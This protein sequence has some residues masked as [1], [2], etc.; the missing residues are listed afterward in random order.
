[1][2]SYISQAQNLVASA[3]GKELPPEERKEKAI[4][5]AALLLQ[6]AQQVQTPREAQQQAFIASLMEDRNSKL[7]FTEITDQCFRSNHASRIADQ[8]RFLIHKRGIPKGLPLLI[9]V[10]LR[11]FSMFSRAVPTFLVPLAKQAIRKEVA[12]VVIPGEPSAL[13]AYL[14]KRTLEGFRVNLNHLGEAIL[15]E[16]E[17]ED[18][19]RQNIEDLK[20]P[21]IEYISVKISSICSQ[22]NLLAFNETLELLADRLRKLYRT[23]MANTFEYSDGERV[24]KFV[25]LDMEEYRDLALTVALFQKVLDE[26]EFFHHS[27]G[28]VLQS[29]IPDSFTYQQKLTKWAIERQKRGGAP[30]KIRIVKGANLGMERV[31]ASLH[32]WPQAPF[33]HKYEADANFKKMLLYGCDP[34]HASA[35]YLGIGS[36]NLFDIALALI[37]RAENNLET[38]I[39]FEMLEGMAPHISRVVKDVAGGLLLYSPAA[40]EK[41]FHTAVAYL[42]RRLDENTAPENFLSALFSMTLDSTSWDKQV[43]EFSFSFDE[44]A[45]VTSNPNRTQ[46]RSKRENID[47]ESLFSNEPD[48]DWSQE[49]NRHWIYGHLE[50]WKSKQNCSIPL[51]SIDH[52]NQTVAC[53]KNGWTATLEERSHYLAKAAQELRQSRGELICAMVADGGKTVPEADAEVSEAIDFCEYYRRDAVELHALE[54]ISWKPLG[55]VVIASPWNFPCSI[56]AGG[57]AAAL[58][59]GN[60]VIFK[61]SSET[62]LVGWKVAEAFWRAGI[63]KNILQFVT[64]DDE[65]VGTALIQHPDV[66][67]VILT[68]ATA[69]AQLMLKLNPKLHLC[70]ETGGKNSII[71]TEMADRDLAIRDIIHSAFSHSGQKCSAC[72]LLIL[73]PELY[74][75]PHFRK[76]LCD[77]A[78]SLPVGSAWDMTTRINPLI[79]PPE[80]ALLKGLTELEEGEEW[81][82]QPKLSK[83]NPC[84]WSPGIKWGVTTTSFS[85]QNELFGPVLSVMKAKNLEH[86]IEIANG[87]KYGLTAGIHTLDQRESDIWEHSIHAGNLYIN[88]GI[89]GAVVLRQPFGGMKQSS[90]GPGAKAGGPNYVIQLMQC[91]QLDPHASDSY[92]YFYENYFSHDHDPVHLIGED[93][94]LR[95]IPKDNCVIR[96]QETDNQQDI[97]KIKSAADITGCHIHISLYNEESNEQLIVYVR[98]EKVQLVRFLNEPSLSLRIALADE[99]CETLIAPVISN[100]RV[101]LL[102]YLK[103]QSIC[104]DY[105]RYGNLGER[106]H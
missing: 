83:N 62:A 6:A 21:E 12:S 36:H 25:N 97:L 78:A 41:D 5:L 27:A 1:M 87:T 95:Y 61:P 38:N 84:L 68:G 74:D 55:V 100:G 91:S 19:L 77:A 8:L 59:A 92:H 26:P 35:V 45:K 17:A 99:G 76:Q 2:S 42:M 102:H 44:V 4:S 72:S 39:I 43:E 22:I 80:G 30:I 75:D 58:A 20:Q 16:G 56:S 23:A 96:I 104:T 67:T 82:L 32:G 29:Y 50:E 81:A 94:I 73:L 48:T 15:G 53:A 33:S 28:I 70:A 11:A 24:P 13:K 101:E 9:G 66:H 65:T 106:S 49:A 63:P 85:Y 54:G 18:R 90:Y 103:E 52:I 40:E 37:L 98:S 86:A 71:V 60:T 7:F 57:I 88:R 47:P 69:T 51:T 14:K 3:K 34:M 10:E 105:H 79:K 31:E 46:N 64:G 93:N 89:T